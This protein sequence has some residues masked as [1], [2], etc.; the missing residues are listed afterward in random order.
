MT[1]VLDFRAG[2]AGKSVRA[3]RGGNESSLAEVVLGL[4]VS[5]LGF[6]GSVHNSY[7]NGE[8]SVALDWSVDSPIVPC[9]IHKPLPVRE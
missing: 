6:I 3:I 4:E 2:K 5:H 1:Y 7:G 8:D 9:G